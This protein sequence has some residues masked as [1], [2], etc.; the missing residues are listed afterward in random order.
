MDQEWDD[1]AVL[2]EYEE[3]D[4]K[5]IALATNLKG[6]GVEVVFEPDEWLDTCRNCSGGDSTSHF[7][8]LCN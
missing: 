7:A 1:I 2:Q 3:H 4:E 6:D 8:L 5:V